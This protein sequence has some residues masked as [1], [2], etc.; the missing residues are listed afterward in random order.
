VQVF[1]A[2]AVGDVKILVHAVS[3]PFRR[4]GG[5]RADDYTDRQLVESR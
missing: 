3:L 1:A 4:G 2:P 5:K